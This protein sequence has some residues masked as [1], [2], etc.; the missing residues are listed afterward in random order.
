MPGTSGVYMVVEGDVATLAL[1]REAA[2]EPASTRLA[3]L[4]DL[5]HQRLYRLA[6]RL[7]RTREEAQDLVQEVVAATPR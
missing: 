5:H 6:R 2:G 7:T 3:A 1:G 4:F